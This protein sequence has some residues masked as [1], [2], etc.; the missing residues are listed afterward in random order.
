MRKTIVI[1]VL[2]LLLVATL[3]LSTPVLAA[4]P[5]VTFDA[6]TDIELSGFSPTMTLVI[7]ANSRVDTIT[8]NTTSIEFSVPVGYTFRIRSNN[9]YT[10]SLSPSNTYAQ[11]TCADSYSEYSVAGV[12]DTTFTITPTATVCT[13]SS[14]GTAPASSSSA[15]S[16]TGTAETPATTETTETTTTTETPTVAEETI[17]TTAGVPA[18]DRAGNITL[19]QMTADAGIVASGDVNQV[20]S[21]MGVSR[22]A[23]AEATYSGTIVAKVVADSGIT[24]Q[25]RNTITNFVTYGTK[26]TKHLGAGERAGVVNSFRAAL[27]R[28]PD[29]SAD[30]NDVIKIANGRWP[31]QT[32]ANTE[33]AA[34]NSFKKIY[35]REP[36]RSNAH[37]DAAV[38]V[39]A[40]GLRPFNRNLN[41][42]KAGIKIFKGIYGYNPSSATDWDA[43]RAIAYSGAT[44]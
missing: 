25:V 5:T 21:E 16:T 38:T 24:A 23:A 31:S 39:M 30:W 12:A 10:M 9:R 20:I 15:G 14:G 18:T 35:L 17:S 43:V 37:D 34:T 3:A 1:T 13:T 19:E 26:A 36:D 32:S 4:D 41:S 27:G 33:T 8:I 6:D 22:D 40:Y 28:L 7:Q 44:R 29:S 42:E 11:F 2:A